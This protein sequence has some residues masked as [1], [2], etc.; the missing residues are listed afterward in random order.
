MSTPSAALDGLARDYWRLAL[1]LSPTMATQLG[2]RHYDHRLSD[3][4]PQGIA[5]PSLVFGLWAAL[6]RDLD[7]AALTEPERVT[8]SQLLAVLQDEIDLRSTGIE[9]WL[10]DPMD[11]PQVAFLNL[12]AIQPVR[13]AEEA[14][15]LV[16]R[17]RAMGPWLDQH[18]ENLARGLATGL[19]SAADPARK[20]ASQLDELV[21]RPPGE[22]PLVSEPLAGLP[23]SF[24]PPARV[25][26]EGELVAAVRDVVA[27]AFARFRA[28]V[29]ERALPA[30][31]PE[32]RS[33]IGALPGGA[34]T[35]RRLIRVHTS[36]ELEA[37]SV[38]ATGLAEVARI[39][40][41]MRR[42]GEQVLGASDLEEIRRRLRGDPA[43]HFTTR[44]EIEA[45]AERSLRRA[46]A[47]VPAWFGVLPKTPCQV[48]R[49]EEHEEKFS[50]IAYYRQPATDGSRPGSY[51]VN[52]YAPGTRPRYEAECLAFHEAVPG[53]HTQLAIAQELTGVPEFR[54]HTGPT[55]YVEGWALYTERLCDEMGLYSG[56]LDRIGMLSFDAW[57][58]CRLVVDTGIHA[59][60]WS[61]ARAIRFLLDHTALAE[62]NIENEVDRYISWPGQA[63]A[64]KTG[65]L[66]I[67]RLREEARRRL[68]ERF[69]VR[70]F[71]D[72]VLTSGAVALG[73]LGE[74]VERLVTRAEVGAR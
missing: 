35:Y 27:P 51:Y 73:T 34:D 37:E 42:L 31:R 46:D 54:K 40:D 4:S 1:R 32:S 19:S 7:S 30:V 17:W 66:E 62:N 69:D 2:E 9:T 13:S 38:H 50:T 56:D 8:R 26:F 41:E 10:L 60:G 43:L 59:L 70:A 24:D 68:G 21:A 39:D 12:P 20:V 16:E 48:C 52:T 63:L 65:Q 44:D 15:K 53:H 47:A 64:Y 14:A 22:W 29:R 55:A 49:I 28:F 23:A 72:A 67:L 25:R 58:A 11:G 33:G 61:R 36:L 45:T 74:I 5:E 71:H 3:I 6:A 57:R 18:I